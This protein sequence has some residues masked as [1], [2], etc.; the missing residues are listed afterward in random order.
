MQQS[1]LKGIKVDGVLPDQRRPLGPKRWV[2]AIVFGITWV[3]AFF[4]LVS[5]VPKFG[6]VFA[7]LEDQQELPALTSWLMA[8]ARLNDSWFYLP[9]ILLIVALVAV[10][11]LMVRK[12]GSNEDAK[13]LLWLWLTLI[14]LGGLIAQ[15]LEALALVLPVFGMSSKIQ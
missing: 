12:L 6:P 15:I 8:L 7:R 13:R 1:T 4:V 9:T 14:G 10:D 5:R 3:P 11:R 2:R